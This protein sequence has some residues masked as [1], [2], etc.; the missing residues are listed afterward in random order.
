MPALPWRTQFVTLAAI[1]G[2]SFLCIKVLGR[3]WPA[4]DVALGR[5]LLGAVFLL[6]VLAIRRER[7][8]RGAVWRHLAIVGLLMNAIPF[9]LFA[10]GE[11]KVSSILAGLW[12]ATTPLMTLLVLLTVMRDEPL[13]GRRT[14]LR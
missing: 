8:P 9:S 5:V 2:S 14:A 4:F 7:L 12:N 13:T 1:W 6:A 10:Y 11:T 3:H